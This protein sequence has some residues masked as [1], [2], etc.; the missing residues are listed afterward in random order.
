MNIFWCFE[1]VILTAFTTKKSLLKYIFMILQITITPGLQVL[2]PVNNPTPL[3]NECP[4][5]IGISGSGQVNHNG[6]IIDNQLLIFGGTKTENDTYASAFELFY[7][8]LLKPFDNTNLP[9]NLIPEGSLPISTSFSTVSVS[10]DNS[11]IFLF[12]GYITNKKKD[13]D[14]SSLVYTYNYH[15]KKWNT[16]TISG[17]IPP[18]RQSMRGVIDDS[19]IIYIFG[20]YNATNVKESEYIGTEYNDMNILN[21]T[22]MTWS[23]LI[24]FENLPSPCACYSA[25]I[26]SN[27]IIVYVGGIEANTTNSFPANMNNIRL[28]DT[29]K[30]EWS[31]MNATG[32]TVDSRWFHTSVL[33]PDGYII[34]FGGCIFEGEF[35]IV[36]SVSPNLAVL[37][38]NKSPF[39]WSIPESSKINSPPSI[40]G[41]EASLY[42]NYMIITFGFLNGNSTWINSAYNSDVYLYDITSSKWVTNFNPPVVINNQTKKSSSKALVIGLAT[43]G[44]VFIVLILIVAFI[45]YKKRVKVLRMS[46]SIS[47][48]SQ[49]FNK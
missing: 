11:T 49:W 5:F 20:G 44:G 38:T 22:K 29:N 47:N 25:N 16:P 7:L 28:F 12:G 23:T 45:I 48:R 46:G 13:Y 33:T 26:L 42:Y 9:W 24:I 43:G 27:G 19:G 37:D 32:E 2:A 41:H 31:Q 39:E 18:P 3:S 10:S 21:T 1:K 40:S 17:D 15:T 35:G 6:V 4:V 8:D 36:N 34:I 30:Y 14:Y